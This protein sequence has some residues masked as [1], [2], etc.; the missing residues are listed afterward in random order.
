MGQGFSSEGNNEYYDWDDDPY[1]DWDDDDWY[2]E[3]SPVHG[4]GNGCACVHES[5]DCYT[6]SD[7]LDPHDVWAKK[8]IGKNCSTRAWR[9]MER[10][11]RRFFLRGTFLIQ[12]VQSVQWRIKNLADEQS[13][14]K[15]VLEQ[16]LE[17]LFVRI[18]KQIAPTKSDPLAGFNFAMLDS[19]AFEI[20]Y[21]TWM[22]VHGSFEHDL[23]EQWEKE[24]QLKLHKK[25]TDIPDIEAFHEFLV[26]HDQAL[27][28]AKSETSN[29]RTAKKQRG[30]KNHGYRSKKSGKNGQHR[31]EQDHLI[32]DTRN[33]EDLDDEDS[34]SDIPP[35][36]T[37]DSFI[38]P[39][40]GLVV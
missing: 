37:L 14:M 24:N 16:M 9:S 8:Y 22:Y 36:P 19:Q 17:L 30:A 2:Y 28:I 11:L 35:L 32:D 7:P 3:V 27:L 33:G 23:F 5:A 34:V 38:L 13:E 40:L 4:Y 25:N 12:L 31:F 10:R 21:D 26:R 15:E 39:R 29:N 6:E 20:M 1:D 18:D